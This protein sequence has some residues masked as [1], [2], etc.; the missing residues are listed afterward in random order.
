VK[1]QHCA[2]TVDSASAFCS[3]ISDALGLWVAHMFPP[4]VS[5]TFSTTCFTCFHVTSN[6]KALQIVSST[7]H[8]NRD[9]PE[10]DPVLTERGTRWNGAAGRG[11]CIT[12]AATRLV[13]H[14]GNIGRH[15]GIGC[16][17][18]ERKVQRRGS[19][20]DAVAFAS[21][22]I[23][24]RDSPPSPLRSTSLSAGTGDVDADVTVSSV[25]TSFFAACQNVR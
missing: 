7:W 5:T 22:N 2:P 17:Q 25:R 21:A 16:V 11:D 1:G 20:T 13:K 3:S 8:R 19:T 12:A 24:A 9:T 10:L 6:E 4:R 18:T 14:T 23:S 15:Q